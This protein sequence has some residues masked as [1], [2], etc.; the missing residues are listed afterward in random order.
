MAQICCTLKQMRDK[1]FV[2]KTNHKPNLSL[3]KQ[4]TYLMSSGVNHTSA[5]SKTIEPE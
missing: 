2:R 4:E 5:A 1:Y 3:R